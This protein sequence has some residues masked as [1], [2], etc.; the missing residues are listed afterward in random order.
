VIPVFSGCMRENGGTRDWLE[1][2]DRYSGK[3]L[4][5]YKLTEMK[6]EN[7]IEE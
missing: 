1:K 3:F 4:M 2:I 6:E 7:E 5:T